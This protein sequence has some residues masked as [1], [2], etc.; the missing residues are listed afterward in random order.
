M[1][2]VR[3]GIFKLGDLKAEKG[4]VIRDAELSWQKDWTIVD[5]LPDIAVP[6]LVISGRYDEA[7]PVAVTPYA[8]LI[9]GARWEVVESFLRGTP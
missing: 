1:S 6:T 7:T 5:R 3:T 9:P 8:D 2:P 4:G